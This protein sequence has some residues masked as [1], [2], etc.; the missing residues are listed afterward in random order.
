VVISFS[1]ALARSEQ[2]RGRYLL[3]GN[4]FSIACKPDIFTYGSLYDRANFDGMPEVR[5]VFERLGTR[6]FEQVIQALQTSATVVPLF[7]GRIDTAMIRRSAAQLKELLVQTIASNHPDT[8][9]D[10]PHQQFWA[11]RRF[12]SHF[13]GATNPGKV[14]SLNYDLLLY[15][16]VM[17]EDDPFAEDQIALDAKDGFGRDDADA[18]AEY[19]TWQGERNYSQTIHY[20]HGAVHLFDAG[21]ELQK[22]TW[23]NTRI[24]LIDQ[25]RAAL[26]NNKF[27]LFVAEG[28]SSAKLARIKHSAYLYHNFK[29]FARCME[30]RDKCL[31]VYGHSLAPNDQHILNK[32]GRGKIPHIFVSL[33]GDPEAPGNRAI[34]AQ[35]NGLMR[36]RP[37]RFPLAVTYFDAASASVW[38]P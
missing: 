27:P 16:T 19:V 11:C 5:A 4:G 3:I 2:F 6:D 32:I 13:I 35:A 30:A 20:L 34:V 7:D 8:P 10:I 22:Y 29:S 14:Y 23:I 1:D 28:E 33:F 12:L 18:A 38:G 9:L 37:E 26:D 31:F 24:R 25:A 36:M 15:W 21:T 17:H